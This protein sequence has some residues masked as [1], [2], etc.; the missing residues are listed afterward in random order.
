MNT[1]SACAILS[2]RCFISFVAAATFIC[3]ADAV[4]AQAGGPQS[5]RQR[6]VPPA[7]YQN[8]NQ[9]QNAPTADQ[10]L[11]QQSRDQRGQYGQSDQSNRLSGRSDQYSRS[12]DRQSRGG[13][14]DEQEDAAWLGV[15][16]KQ[17]GDD[18]GATIEHVY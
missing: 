14:S 17:R 18:H 5:S 9:S 15:F 10:Q 6:N 7:Q 4:W 1:V 8:Q 11:N 12:S 2:L 13:Q 3:A 16:L